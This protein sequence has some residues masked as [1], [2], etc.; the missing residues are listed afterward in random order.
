MSRALE[1]IVETSRSLA[2][3]P[4]LSEAASTPRAPAVVR[5]DTAALP[6]NTAADA[7]PAQ[8][9]LVVFLRAL[10][11]T[12]EPA[13]LTALE[14][15]GH[16]WDQVDAARLLD[17]ATRERAARVIG[18]WRKVGGAPAMLAVLTVHAALD[19]ATLVDRRLASL[20]R[21][22]LR[23]VPDDLLPGGRPFLDVARALRETAR[24][25]S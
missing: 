16:A 23:S 3:P 15:A 12:L 19:L 4:L 7:R 1:Q 18:A 22:R 14:R 24:R 6:A 21:L 11:D 13:L 9:E 17:D 2:G 8:Q 25:W 5:L 10:A 20:V